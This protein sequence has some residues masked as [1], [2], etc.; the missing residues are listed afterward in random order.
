MLRF[1]D[2]RISGPYGFQ[3]VHTTVNGQLIMQLVDNYYLITGCKGRTRNYKPK[4]LHTVR[5][6]EGC[7]ENFGLVFPGTAR[8]LQ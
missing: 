3:D 5:A 4:V 1:D 2:Y 6:Y 8:A 7:L